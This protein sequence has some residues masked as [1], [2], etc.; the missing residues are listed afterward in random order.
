MSGSRPGETDLAERSPTL[1]L[2]QRG[3]LFDCR[4]ALKRRLEFAFPPRQ[5]HH[6]TLPA[7]PSKP[8]WDRALLTMPFIGLV[9]L[10]LTPSSNTG[11]V[12][13]CDAGWLVYLGCKN[14]RPEHLLEGD[15]LGVG[16]L[17]LAGLAIALLHGWSE[18]GLG[19]F[20][21]KS[22]DNAALQE[23]VNEEI[24]V[25]ALQVDCSLS[26][27][28]PDAAE[29][30]PEFLRVGAQWDLPPIGGEKAKDLPPI[31]GQKAKDLPPIGGETIEQVRQ[32]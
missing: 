23:F 7:R 20:W 25:V 19:S 28:D 27:V 29:A 22:V 30:L 12:F 14:Q 31:G 10:G 26:V 21:V 24:G 15:P 32:S 3:P 8:T 16:Q 9:W 2:S 1:R 17:G 11:R 6:L 4:A 5:F 18:Q 13:H